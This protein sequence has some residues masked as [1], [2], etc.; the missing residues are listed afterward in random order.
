MCQKGLTMRTEL[1]ETEMTLDLI[2]A[3]HKTPNACLRSQC[4]PQRFVF[5]IFFYCCVEDNKK[6][7]KLQEYSKKKIKLADTLW[8][9][10]SVGIC[11][12]IYT[13][14]TILWNDYVKSKYID[15]DLIQGVNSYEDLTKMLKQ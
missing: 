6:F 14:N 11:T 4:I 5:W 13:C 8:R 1:L 3:D 10:Q 9:I 12:K 7:Y 2:K 15:W